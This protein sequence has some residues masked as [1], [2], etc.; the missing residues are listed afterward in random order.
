MKQRCL[1]FNAGPLHL[2]AQ[3]AEYYVCQRKGLLAG[4]LDRAKRQQQYIRALMTKVTTGEFITNPVKF[5]KLIRTAAG[6]VTVDKRMPVEG[7]VY[8]LKSLRPAN[9]TFVAIDLNDLQLVI[10]RRA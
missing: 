9:L 1:T 10:A 8:S 4:D 5:D 7:L 6:A 3:L 2:D